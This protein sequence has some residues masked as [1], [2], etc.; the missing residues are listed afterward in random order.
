MGSEAVLPH[1]NI[2]GL[3]RQTQILGTENSS[4]VYRLENPCLFFHYQC[5]HQPWKNPNRPSF[6]TESLVRRYNLG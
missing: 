1:R 4:S 3:S 6:F 5:I 2:L